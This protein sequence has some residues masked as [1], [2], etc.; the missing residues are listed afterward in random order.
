MRAW[1]ELVLVVIAALVVTGA[2]AAAV[3]GLERGAGSLGLTATLKLVST[4]DGSCPPGVSN[5]TECPSRR[6]SGRVAGLGDVTVRYSYLADL[7]HPSC[8]GGSVKILE[9]PV[10][11][12]VKSKG[13]LEIAVAARPDCLSPAAGLSAAQSFTI[14]GGTGVYAGASGSG[15]VSRSLSQTSSGAAGPETWKGTLTVAELEFDVTR[16]VLSGA[17]GKRVN[18]PRGARSARVTFRVSAR[19]DR[20][21]V[22]PTTCAPK[23]GSRFKLGKTRVTC[24]AT[25]ESGNL[26]TATFAITVKAR[27]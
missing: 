26:A 13:D 6:G 9:Y 15:T 10:R 12:T 25:D 24:S 3:S 17:T 1:R 16:P 2:T 4:L 5:T 23:S 8:S 11:L 18:A 19:D 7:G 21:G 20:D 27:K 22:L 14:T